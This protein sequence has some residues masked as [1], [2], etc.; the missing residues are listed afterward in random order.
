MTLYSEYE[1]PADL[2]S[3]TT[4]SEPDQTFLAR[5]LDILQKDPNRDPR[6]SFRQA[7][8]AVSASSAAAAAAQSASGGMTAS[9]SGTGPL[10]SSISDSGVVGPMSSSAGGLNLPAVEKAMAEMEGGS[11]EDLR[12]KFA[13]LGRKVHHPLHP[14]HHE[15]FYANECSRIP[16]GVRLHQP[17]LVTQAVAQCPTRRCTTLSVHSGPLRNRILG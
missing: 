11:A 13:K 9:G 2:H 6:A 12:E 17:P 5:Q 3:I 1:Q 8:A 10:A 7:A 4:N 15:G 16:H 14:L